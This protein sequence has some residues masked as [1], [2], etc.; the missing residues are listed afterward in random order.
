[1]IDW[2]WKRFRKCFL[3][4]KQHKHSWPFPIYI[5]LP[6][7]P[8]FDFHKFHWTSPCRNDISAALKPSFERVHYVSQ[9]FVRMR[10]KTCFKVCAL[11]SNILLPIVGIPFTRFSIPKAL[12]SGQTPCL[13]FHQ[14]Q[15][16]TRPLCLIPTKNKSSKKILSHTFWMIYWRRS[17]RSC[18]HIV[19]QAGARV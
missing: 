7:N 6:T 15:T 3:L 12:R 17:T 18:R 4:T 11:N 9:D 13:L 19:D 8:Y 1:M 2:S 16:Q 10:R 5:C 14:L